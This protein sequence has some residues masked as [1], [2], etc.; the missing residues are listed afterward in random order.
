MMNLAAK[1]SEAPRTMFCHV[2]EELRK[3]LSMM[4]KFDPNSRSSAEELLTLPIFNS[5]RNPKLESLE[6]P[7]FN[8]SID[9]SSCFDYSN[10]EHRISADAYLTILLNE[11]NTSNFIN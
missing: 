11:I 10:S 2:S 1:P 3:T 6:M 9:E 8:L 5:I 7:A 4:L